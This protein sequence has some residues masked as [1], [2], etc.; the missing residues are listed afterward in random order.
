[1]YKNIQVY[2]LFLLL[3]LVAIDYEYVLSSTFLSLPL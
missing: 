2:F 1:M 3:H